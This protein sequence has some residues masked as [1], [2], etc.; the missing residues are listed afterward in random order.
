MKHTLY[1]KGMHCK[2]C[3]IVIK[4]WINEIEWCHVEALSHRTWKLIVDMKDEDALADIKQAIAEAGYETS[5]E[6][7]SHK[8]FFTKEKARNLL[9]LLPALL[10]LAILFR[11]NVN[12]LIPQYD[13]LT[14]GIA[15]VVGLVASIST[16]LAVTGG[17][18]VGYTES[19][20]TKNNIRTQA[21]FHIGRLIA[22]VIGWAILGM[23]GQ[24]FQWSIRFNVIFSVIVGIVLAYIGLQLL[25]LVPNITKLWFHLPGWISKPI[26]HLKNP[27]FAPLVGALTFFLPCG[28]TQS[29][30]LLA[31]QS[32]DPLKGAMIMAGFAIGTIPVLFGIGLGSGYVKD[33]LKF[34]NPL[35]A[36][37]LVVFGIYTLRNGY[38]LVNA[39]NVGNRPPVSQTANLETETIQRSHDGIGFQPSVLKLEK[40]KNYK[41]V[42]TPTSNGLG[43]M[44]T[45]VVPGKWVIQIKEWQSFTIDVNGS[46]AKKTRLVCA[47]M[48]MRQ[49]DIVVQ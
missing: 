30:Q 29:M 4:K 14:F 2:S 28:F 36:S 7:E 6:K 27:K 10:L 16:C 39:I 21:K 13:K 48:G 32:S 25:W 33:K 44:S 37:L 20:D 22:F 12:G 5:G 24:N 26:Y 8:A 18:V 42:V 31:L 38:S 23:L 1:V 15:L 3:E 35:I 49:G 19:V 41:I 9:W 43:C 40:G 45:V 47:S 11:T 17:I 34:L 46:K